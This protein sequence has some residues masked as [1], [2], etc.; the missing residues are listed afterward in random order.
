MGSVSKNKQHRNKGKEVE[1]KEKNKANASKRGSES[2]HVKERASS[3]SSSFIRGAIVVSMFMTWSGR[4]VK[5]GEGTKS[6]HY[7]GMFLQ[8][9]L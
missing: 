3:L 6:V 2:N 9:R 5:C 4:L 1:R 8:V 7:A